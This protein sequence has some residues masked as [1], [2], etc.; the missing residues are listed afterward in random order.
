M[1][2]HYSKPSIRCTHPRLIIHDDGHG[3]T[4]HL[5]HPSSVTIMTIG[6]RLVV[7]FSV[8]LLLLIGY[9]FFAVD[10]VN[11]LSDL[12]DRLYQ[13]PLTVSNA[14]L[15]TRQELIGIHSLMREALLTEDPARLQHMRAEIKAWETQALNHLALVR[16]RFL[17]D[18]AQVDQVEAGI[19]AWQP[20]RAQVLALHENGDTE[21]ALA[22][23]AGADAT[24]V[25]QLNADI[26]GLIDFAKTKAATFLS[27]AHTTRA[28]SQR[29]TWGIMIAFFLLG[30]GIAF[31]MTRRIKTPL[32]LLC[33]ATREVANGNLE[34]TISYDGK[35]ELGN[36]A[37]AFNQMTTQVRDGQTLIAE[38]QALAQEAATDAEAARQEAETQQTYLASHVDTILEAMQ[39]FA[40]GDL[41]VQLPTHQADEIGKLFS[42]FNQAVNNM[43]HML[44]EVRTAASTS[45]A[46]ATAISTSTD[47]I[48]AA[49]HEQSAQAEEVA[50]SMDQM[51]K[52]I[53]E[54]A[55]YASQAAQVARQSGREAAAGGQVVESTLA[56]IREI[57]DAFSTSQRTVEQLGKASATIGGILALINDIADQTNLLAL[58]ASI[59]AARAGEHG[60]S[61]T[62]VANEVRD[63]A[64]RTRR[65]TGEIAT[66]IETI[67]SDTQQAVAHM[68]HGAKEVETGLHLAD[69]AGRALDVIVER[70]GETEAA[71]IQIASATEEQS[72][73][74]EEI[75]HN[76]ESISRVSAE[77]AEDV[78]RIA[79]STGELRQRTD[80]LETL[81]LRFSTARPSP[82]SS[83]GDDDTTPRAPVAML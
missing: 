30:S 77:V 9:G 50:T 65:A 55:S 36:L 57:A 69:Q 56:K 20:I 32:G 49:A 45:A 4:S 83:Q 44:A 47:Q 59:E 42:G 15:E 24:H 82:V 39:R 33:D 37:R 34:H 13:H 11:T 67:Q 53:L 28:W 72:A 19:L 46:T 75:A 63:L 16:E 8:F 66:M 12:T 79:S 29:W 64:A 1:F 17:G 74:V 23:L 51:T 6:Q 60:K 61:F 7:S 78:T 48:A 68:A 26:Q 54:N 18:P 22:L 27:N 43:E 81:L 10:R 70:A 25:A 71:V 76:I 73:T 62:V 35:D 40:N 38:Q 21:A 58:N 31:M 5:I 3:L 14:V 2:K 41:H 80:E 52:T